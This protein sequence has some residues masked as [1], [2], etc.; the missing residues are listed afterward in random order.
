MLLFYINS[1]LMFYP[2]ICFRK[3]RIAYPKKGCI[4]RP[5]PILLTPFFHPA[6]GYKQAYENLQ[7]VENSGG[8][9]FFDVCQVAI[10]Y[11]SYLKRIWF[12]SSL[13]SPI[14]PPYSNMIFP[15]Q[16]IIFSS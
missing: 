3:Q 16:P 7:L 13:A 15:A 4:S 2:K 9:M 1:I 10:N 8:S 14:P 11:P 12:L 5:D 6:Y